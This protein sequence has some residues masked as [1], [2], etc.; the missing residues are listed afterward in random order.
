MAI[1]LGYVYRNGN[2]VKLGHNVGSLR[3]RFKENTYNNN[4]K[5]ITKISLKLFFIGFLIAITVSINKNNLFTP[6][7]I[8]LKFANN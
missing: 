7:L 3:W 4:I 2:P 8:L 5:K 1:A 6:Y